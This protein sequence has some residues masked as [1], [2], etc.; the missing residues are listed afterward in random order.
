M[1]LNN[2]ERGVRELI[3]SI[4]QDN[5]IKHR[6]T[7]YVITTVCYA[8]QP[9][10]CIEYPGPVD[11]TYSAGTVFIRAWHGHIQEE[12]LADPERFKTSNEPFV[13]YGGDV[14]YEQ[15]EIMLPDFD[16]K[17]SLLLDRFIPNKIKRPSLDRLLYRS[18]KNFVPS[19][20][21]DLKPK[22]TTRFQRLKHWFKRRFGYLPSVDD[23][24]LRQAIRCQFHASDAEVDDIIMMATNMKASGLPMSFFVKMADKLSSQR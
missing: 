16:K 19:V 14:T 10:C 3:R 12:L 20:S 6:S 24:Y 23:F 11:F 18:S 22:S 13:E 7:P 15:L 21:F 17:L 9:F 2:I 4:L 8:H 5:G 1:A